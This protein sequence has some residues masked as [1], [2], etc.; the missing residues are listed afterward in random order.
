MSPSL[1]GPLTFLIM[2]RWESSWNSTLTWV[3][4]PLDPV[5]PITLITF[6]RTDGSTSDYFFHNLRFKFLTIIHFHILNWFFCCC[7]KLHYWLIRLD[8]MRLRWWRIF[9]ISFDKLCDWLNL[10]DFHE[11]RTSIAELKRVEQLKK[12]T[13]VWNKW[14]QKN[15]KTYHVCLLCGVF[16]AW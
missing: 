1:T 2:V 3:I 8:F 5:F 14:N 12:R 11:R 9:F 6:A 13:S 15:D 16:V 4:P 10:W 7:W